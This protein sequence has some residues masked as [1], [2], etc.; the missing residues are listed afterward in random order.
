MEEDIF[1]KALR[2]LYDCC[3]EKIGLQADVI[4][5]KEEEETE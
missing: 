1:V 2:Y 5:T 4:V 3:L